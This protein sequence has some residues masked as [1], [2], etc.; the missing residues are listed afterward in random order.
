M[1]FN[2]S[3]Q[4]ALIVV[5]DKILVWVQTI[6]TM[7]PNLLVAALIIVGFAFLARFTHWGIKKIYKKRRGL[8]S[9][10]NIIAAN[11]GYFFV[12]IL[13]VFVALSVLNLDKT[14][15]SLLAGAGVIGLALGFAFQDTAA[16]F[17]AG[18]FIAFRS[19]FNKGDFIETGKFLG[20]VKEINL[21]ATIMETVHGLEVIIP[22]KEVYQNAIINYTSTQRRRVDIACGVSYADDLDKAEQLVLEAVK[23][24]KSLATDMDN[25]ISFVYE[26][27]GESSIDFKV[28]IWLEEST[29]STYISV[30]SEVIKKIKKAFDANG[31]SIP[32]PIRTLDFGIAGGEKLSEALLLGKEGGLKIP[33]ERLENN[34]ENEEKEVSKNGKK[35]ETISK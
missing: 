34:V 23:D 35:D 15:T 26:E 1:K 6:I 32:F 12:L 24:I 2:E 8:N 5:Q 16:N 17:I 20:T 33:K 19:P 28:R 4:E 7:L 9:N 10:L 31:I 21:R 30:R 11:I 14:V 13:G 25:P 3:I 22:N 18:L 29:Q 27:F